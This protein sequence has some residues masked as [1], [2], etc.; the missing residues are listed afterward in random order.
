MTRDLLEQALDPLRHL[1]SWRATRGMAIDD[2]AAAA[3]VPLAS[4]YRIESGHELPTW[5]Q[6]VGMAEALSVPLRSLF[7]E[8]E[9][10]S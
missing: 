1:S 7:E 5:E 10:A 6:L 9:S 8:P 2:L 3:S 4:L